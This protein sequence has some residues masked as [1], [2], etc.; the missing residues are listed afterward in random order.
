MKEVFES[1]PDLMRELRDIFKTQKDKVSY[2]DL[3]QFI[4][5]KMDIKLENWEEDALEGRLDRLGMAFI[6]FNEFN[7]FSIEYGISWGEPLIEG[8]MEDIL[9]AKMNISY[10][11]YKV[12]PTDYFLGCP[13]MLNNEKAAL[14]KCR[15]IWHD[16]KKKKN[17]HYMDP[18]FGPK[19]ANDKAG[20]ENSLYK[21][22]VLPQKGYPEPKDI[23][24]K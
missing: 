7:E 15:S 22:G 18:D 5:H 10:K 20:S 6:E 19:D 21:N 12:S 14:S 4:Q 23:E 16:M 13:T 24:W 1:N 9:D 2:F 11:D 3:F 8:D 17:L